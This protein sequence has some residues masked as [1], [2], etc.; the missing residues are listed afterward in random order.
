MKSVQKKLK[1]ESEKLI[2]DD[3]TPEIVTSK[4]SNC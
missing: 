2:P 3:F 4:F 1:E